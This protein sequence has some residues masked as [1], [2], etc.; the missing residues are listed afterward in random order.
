[1]KFDDEI[2]L[3]DDYNQWVSNLKLAGPDTS[4]AAFMED[5]AKQ[6]AFERLAKVDEYL[7]SYPIN[8]ALIKHLQSL[9]DGKELPTSDEDV[10]EAEVIDE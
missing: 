5:R 2:N 3:L 6:T 10:V 4:P 8:S 9:V 7:K 1:M